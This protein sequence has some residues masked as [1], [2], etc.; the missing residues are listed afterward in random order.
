M[1]LQKRFLSFMLIVFLGLAGA[2]FIL[3]AY[4]RPEGELSDV[5][6]IV[7]IA[8]NMVFNKNNPTLVLKVGERVRFIIINKDRGMLHDFV[9]EELEVFIPEPL[10]YSESGSTEFTPAQKGEFDYFCSFHSIIMRGKV[11]IKD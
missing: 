8:K 2:L 4:E 9:I 6:E 7:L 1:A 10:K 11:I 5:K 3:E